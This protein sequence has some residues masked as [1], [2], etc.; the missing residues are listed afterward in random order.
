MALPK[1]LLTLLRPGTNQLK[2]LPELSTQVLV[3]GMGKTQA[4][5]DDDAARGLTVE[6][7]PLHEANL[8][9]LATPAGGSY[10]RVT[11][12]D[13]D[14]QAI[15][16]N[17]DHHFDLTGDSARPWLDGGYYLVWPVAL[18]FCCGFAR[19]GLCDGKRGHISTS[20]VTKK[21]PAS[22]SGWRR[23]WIFAF[24]SVWGVAAPQSFLNL[25][26]TPDQQG[27]LWFHLGKYDRAARAFEDSRWRGMSY[28]AAQ[29]FAAAAQYF[30]QYTDQDS[31]LAQAMRWH[32]K[33]TTRRPSRF[34]RT[35][36]S[37]F[38]SIQVRR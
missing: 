18:L 36:P 13:A 23:W 35:L 22:L 24:V 7:L 2:P 31:L 14:I 29:D 4:Q 30:S 17:I 25:W 27:Q 16:R 15:M 33:G 9:A 32:I 10:Q 37:N 5:L 20:S 3:W 8:Q 11:P 28:Y 26:L 6:A 34:I 21:A 38:Q 1:Q 19:D 12:D